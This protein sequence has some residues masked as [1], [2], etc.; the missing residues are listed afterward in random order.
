MVLGV[1]IDVL[2]LR[3]LPPENL[4]EDDP[5]VRRVFTPKETAQARVC[6]DREGFL[7]RCFA[8]K[9]AA[10]KAVGC[11]SGGVRGT[12]AEILEDEEGFPFCTL[13]GVLAKRARERGGSKMHV[14]FSREGD[15]VLAFALLE[16]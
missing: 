4:R 13:H 9:E 10:F 1:G 12:D 5:F 16:T 6:G 3:R 14:S 7:A 15:T 8:G 11:P 2:D